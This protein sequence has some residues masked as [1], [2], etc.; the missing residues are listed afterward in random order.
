MK[1]DNA[2]EFFEELERKG[3]LMEK[4]DELIN[5]ERIPEFVS[6]KFFTDKQWNALTGQIPMTQEMFDRTLHV[7]DQVKDGVNFH[8]IVEQFPELKVNFP[9]EICEKYK[10]EHD[11]YKK[12]YL[13]KFGDDALLF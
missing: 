1:N 5:D 12:D 8:R 11:D 7:C 10:K 3:I 2:L 4:L 6:D 9:N 13:E